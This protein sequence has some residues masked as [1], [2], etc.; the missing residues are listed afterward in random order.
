MKRL[1]VVVLALFGLACD[2]HIREVRHDRDAARPAL[3][4]ASRP[5]GIGVE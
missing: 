5:T 1:L 2:K 4:D 3:A